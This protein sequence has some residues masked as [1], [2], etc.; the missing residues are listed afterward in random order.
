M[1]ETL[2]EFPDPSTPYVSIPVEINAKQ[3]DGTRESA[4]KIIDWAG[5]DAD[6][7]W[8]NE[9]PQRLIVRTL[10]GEMKANPTDWIIRG[11]EGE[12]YPCK[13]TVFQR[14][15]RKRPT[16]STEHT[17]IELSRHAYAENSFIIDHF[18]GHLLTSRADLEELYRKLDDF[19][20][21][22]PGYEPR[23]A[24]AR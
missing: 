21:P 22:N 11:T 16:P 24:E 4:R 20:Y 12:H 9:T 1:P 5:E 8:T 10:E 7:R 3:W 18:T 6:I 23:I 2:L 17:S 19:L 14:K 15:Y 13:D